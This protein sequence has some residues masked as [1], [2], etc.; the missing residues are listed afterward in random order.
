MTDFIQHFSHVVSEFRLGVGRRADRA[1]F[2]IA[3]CL[4]ALKL[5]GERGSAVLI[6][7]TETG[8]P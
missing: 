7:K 1:R 5:R 3:G 2:S 8:K 6:S 4:P